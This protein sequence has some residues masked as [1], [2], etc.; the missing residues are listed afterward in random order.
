MQR[1]RHETKP[2]PGRINK[3]SGQV[4]GVSRMIEEHRE[5]PEILYTISPIH[6]ALGSLEAKSLEDY[7]RHCVSTSSNDPPRLEQQLE[8]IIAL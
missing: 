4:Q 6:S 5:C 8:E 2:L 1:D 3:V 7:V